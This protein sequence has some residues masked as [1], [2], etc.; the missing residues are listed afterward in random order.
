MPMPSL[1][2]LKYKYIAILKT[3]RILWFHFLS[4]FCPVDIFVLSTFCIV[5]VLSCR[6]FVFD[7]LSFD[8]LY[9]RHHSVVQTLS[10]QRLMCLFV[11]S[12]Q[13]MFYN[14]D[15]V[16]KKT[17]DK[18]IVTQ[19]RKPIDNNPKCQTRGR[20]CEAWSELNSVFLYLGPIHF[21][22]QS[23]FK[24]ILRNLQQQCCGVGNLRQSRWKQSKNLKQILKRRIEIIT[25]RIIYF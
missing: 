1:T 16:L 3:F 7:V 15:I 22:Y 11:N 5:D 18:K 24:I 13:T 21:P 20:D 9:V 23:P 4:I 8:V 10:S 19:V 25:V 14:W 12:W 17:Q 2:D 6:R